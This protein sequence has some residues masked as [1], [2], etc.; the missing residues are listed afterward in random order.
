MSFD[1][2]LEIDTG[3]EYTATVADVGNITYNV[4][5]M[6]HEALGYGL[7]QTDGRNAGELLPELR[8]GIADMQDRPAVCTAMNPE[9]GWGNAQVT[10]EY[11][12]GFAAACA[13]HPKATVRVT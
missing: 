9:N 5:P 6:F 12:Q 13:A 10:L 8:K 3:G 2:Y 11:L 4:N 7:R 1:V